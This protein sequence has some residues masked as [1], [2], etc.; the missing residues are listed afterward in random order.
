M[1]ELRA[2]LKLY[3]DARNKILAGAQSYTVAGRNLTYGNLSEIDKQIADLRTRIARL[4]LRGGLV[5]SPL[6]GG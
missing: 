5:K 1:D 4:S 2:E 6:L 3:I